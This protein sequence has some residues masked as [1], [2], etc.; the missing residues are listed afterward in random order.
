MI[1]G[2]TDQ[3]ILARMARLGFEEGR[4]FD[5]DAASPMD[6]NALKDAP[7]I[8]QKPMGWTSPR[9]AECVNQ[10][11]MDN[12]TAAVYG[13]YYLK[14]ALMAQLGLKANLPESTKDFVP[15]LEKGN[16][17]PVNAFW[18]VAL[19]DDNGSQVANSSNRFGLSN[20]M[21]LQ[22][23]PDGSLD[24]YFHHESPGKDANWLP[25]PDGPVQRDPAALRPEAPGLAREM[26][27]PAI[28][29]VHRLSTHTAQ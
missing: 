14:R 9:I 7:V 28:A 23:N 5:F 16:V 19:Y 11:P 20:W 29:K 22:E 2:F 4:S 10:W 3:P 8:A 6:Q 21:P 26:T 24:L 1:T 18:S 13:S 12:D 17:P 25:A 15:R 27:P